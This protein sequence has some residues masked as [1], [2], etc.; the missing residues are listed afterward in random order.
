LLAANVP[1]IVLWE[2]TRDSLAT[3]CDCLIQAARLTP[4]PLQVVASCEL[5]LRQQLNLMELPIG[6][7]VRHPEDLR[8]LRTM[9][10]GYFARHRQLLD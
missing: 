10:Q 4:A 1:S 6:A 2:F 5:S 7:L 9:L 8:R 3:G